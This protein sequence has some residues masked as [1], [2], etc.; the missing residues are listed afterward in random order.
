MGSYAGLGMTQVA[1]SDFS[2]M[3]LIIKQKPALI[4]YTSTTQCT[5][6]LRNTPHETSH[7]PML[8]QYR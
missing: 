5:C 2:Q 7:N 4:K 6:S 8:Q 3:K 1:C